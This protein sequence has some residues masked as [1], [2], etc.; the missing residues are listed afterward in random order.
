MLRYRYGGSKY[1][2]RQPNH[3]PTHNLSP[4]MTDN[5]RRNCILKMAQRIQITEALL[6]SHLLELQYVIDLHRNCTDGER[7]R[8]TIRCNYGNSIEELCNKSI[9]VVPLLH[10]PAACRED[11]FVS[12]VETESLAFL[13]AG[14]RFIALLLSVTS[15]KTA[16]GSDMTA[17]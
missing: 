15:R 12:A 10:F 11:R 4:R 7:M 1:L 9:V 5:R 2:Q 16:P 6:E 13:A 8:R 17:P 14:A 3:L